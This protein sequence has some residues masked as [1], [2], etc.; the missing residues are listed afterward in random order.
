M[1]I[2]SL[3]AWKNNI[4]LYLKDKFYFRIL[5]KILCRLLKSWFALTEQIT[6]LKYCCHALPWLRYL[7]FSCCF[8]S[9]AQNDSTP[10]LNFFYIYFPCN[11]HERPSNNNALYEP[12]A[13]D[14][15]SFLPL[16]PERDEKQ[17]RF[18]I[19]GVKAKLWTWLGRNLARTPLTFPKCLI[20]NV[21][22]ESVA[23]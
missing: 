16:N 18:S 5:V 22:V 3:S 2:L 17:T 12:T 19:T 4:I 14:C 21:T 9:V 20:F 10:A 8:S 11:D 23:L 1:Q 13:M 15:W 7:T 6:E